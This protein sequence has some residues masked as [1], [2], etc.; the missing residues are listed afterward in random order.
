MGGGARRPA[1]GEVGWFR[2]AGG[3]RGGGMRGG[4]EGEGEGG[5]TFLLI[6]LRG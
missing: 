4:G 3:G 6:K 5:V 1:G 2:E